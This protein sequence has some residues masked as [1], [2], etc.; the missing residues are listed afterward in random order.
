MD[1]IKSSIT[2]LNKTDEACKKAGLRFAYHNHDAEFR[3]W[4]ERFR[5]AFFLKKQM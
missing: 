1:D 5:T 4:K 3:A 2:V